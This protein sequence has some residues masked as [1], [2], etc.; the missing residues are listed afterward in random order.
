MADNLPAYCYYRDYPQSLASTVSFDRDYLM[1][2]SSGSIRFG[3]DGRTWTMPSAYAAWIPAN[4]KIEVEITR[5]ATCCSVLYQPDF[6][7]NVPGET[8][9]FAVTPLAREMIYF[10]RRWGPEESEFSAF[11]QN[12]FQSI[13]MTCTELA[14]KPSPIWQPTGSSQ[15]VK[16]ALT[17]TQTN[18]ATNLSFDDVAKAANTSQRTLLRHFREEVGLTWQQSLRRL[19]MIRSIE[20]LSNEDEAIIQVA[21]QV[22]Y[23]SLSAFNKAFREFTGHT[24]SAF[25]S[26][27]TP[28]W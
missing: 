21:Y 6:I 2:A 14:L 20:L 16:R 22:G 5:A 27:K 1:Y 3:V 4:T 8:V 24:P 13:A 25:R 7:E 26:R 12:Y 23:S 10:S 9:V 18:L 15:H 11:A 17:F 28:Q 19:R